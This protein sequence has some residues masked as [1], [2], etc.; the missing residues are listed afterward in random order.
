MR[1]NKY[2]EISGVFLA[3]EDVEIVI[4]FLEMDKK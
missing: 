2:C 3:V 4:V 1:D